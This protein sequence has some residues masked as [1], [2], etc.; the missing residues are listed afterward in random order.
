MANKFFHTNNKKELIAEFTKW[1]T[2]ERAKYIKKNPI[3]KKTKAQKKKIK[4]V[5]KQKEDKI[6]TIEKEILI[7][8]VKVREIKKDV[9]KKNAR[10][11]ADYV[12]K[13]NDR[14]K[15]LDGST[16]GTIKSIEKK[17]VTVNFGFLTTKTTSNKLEIVETSKK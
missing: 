16:V 14:V 9:A 17:T 2:I 10:A 1:A 11:K 3:V 8:V 7:E 13:V 5:E 15:I 4:V 12:F 6:A